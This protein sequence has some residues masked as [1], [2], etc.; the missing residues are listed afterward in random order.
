MGL[1]NSNL[2]RIPVQYQARIGTSGAQWAME[3]GRWM[4][5]DRRGR[6]SLSGSAG[7]QLDSVRE[8]LGQQ[9]VSVTAKSN[10]EGFHCSAV[11]AVPA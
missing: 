2:G 8:V 1:P 9:K 3:S 6:A 11:A 5:M 7:S 4:A 10:V